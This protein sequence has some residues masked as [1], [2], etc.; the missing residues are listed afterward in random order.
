MGPTQHA[1]KDSD[2]PETGQGNHWGLTKHCGAKENIYF[3]KLSGAPE[4]EDGNIVDYA[5]QT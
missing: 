5:T 1:F 2:I 4:S 3:L